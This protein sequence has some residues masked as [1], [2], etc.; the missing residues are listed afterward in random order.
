MSFALACSFLVYFLIIVALAGVFLLS[1]YLRP[2]GIKQSKG[3]EE[4][5]ESGIKPKNVIGFASDKFSVKYYIV[6]IIFV[7]FDIE[8]LF[9]YSWAVSLRELDI[10]GLIEMFL[11]AFILL[12]G[13]FYVYDKKILEWK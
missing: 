3:K 5:Y 9:M 6:A 7:L 1:S 12:L 2:S 8:I 10:L 11:F 4:L 13:L